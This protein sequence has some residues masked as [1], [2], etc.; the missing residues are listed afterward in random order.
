MTASVLI[1]A[2]CSALH[3]ERCDRLLTDHRFCVVGAGAGGLQVGQLLLNRG[4]D[5]VSLAAD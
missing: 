5:Y 4:E 2:A 1:L 3:P